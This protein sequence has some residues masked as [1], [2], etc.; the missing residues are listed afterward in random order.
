[1]IRKLL[2][3]M[4]LILIITFSVNGIARY[5]L[6][7]KELPL[8]YP[9]IET[10]KTLSEDA[11][12][13]QALIDS[14]SFSKPEKYWFYETFSD[15]TFWIKIPIEN[16]SNKEQDIFLVLK[17]AYLKSGDIWIYRSNERVDQ[18]HHFTYKRPMDM[19]LNANFPT[20]SFPLDSYEKAEVYIKIKD[21]ETRTSLMLELLD[22]RAFSRYTTYEI[23][24]VLSYSMFMITIALIIGILAIAKRARGMLFYPIY[25]LFFIVDNA[26]FKGFGQNYIWYHSDFLLN[27][28]RS[29]SHGFIMLFGSLFYAHFYQ[30]FTPGKW[31]IKYFQWFAISLI[32]VFMVYGLK[33]FHDPFPSFY[34]YFWSYLNINLVIMLVIH[35]YLAVSKKLPF[36]LA[37][38]FAL[39]IIGSQVRNHFI[40]HSD[41][42]EWIG[43]LVNNSYFF[44]VILEVSLVSYF[45]IRALYDHQDQTEEELAAI[46]ADKSNLEQ[47]LKDAQQKA[48]IL[49][50]KAV[51]PIAEICHI[52]SD[53]HY[54]EYHLQNQK[55]AEIDRNTMRSAEKDLIAHGFIRT[56]RS[57]LVNKTYIKATYSDKLLLHNGKEIPLSRK[58]ATT[59]ESKL[60]G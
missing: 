26:A 33:I 30:R 21:R 45:V 53:G 14:E 38:A 36:Y 3:A 48:I 47:V 49:K 16:K 12:Q 25:L 39:P 57:Y 55:R 10:A 22:E 60:K 32:P 56:H 7:I 11:V 51:I 17:N 34:R 50:S 54:L 18:G 6:G 19:P 41:M 15:S 27:N 40:A 44:A 52:K 46:K 23:L 31:V 29:L 1:M 28:I 9:Y 58:I 24:G 37:I 43:I 59:I 35:L 13:L 20:W 8:L 42:S 5:P 2:T 4:S